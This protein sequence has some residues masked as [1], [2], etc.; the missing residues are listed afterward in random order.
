MRNA[1]FS[2]HRRRDGTYTRIAL[3]HPRPVVFFTIHLHA[4]AHIKMCVTFGR[5]GRQKWH[6]IVCWM[7]LVVIVYDEKTKEANNFGQFERSRPRQIPRVTSQCILF[8]RSLS[9]PS[10]HLFFCNFSRRVT[11]PLCT[12]RASFLFFHNQTT[13]F[14]FSLALSRGPPTLNFIREINVEVKNFIEIHSNCFDLLRFR[15]MRTFSSFSPSKHMSVA[16]FVDANLLSI[17]TC[18]RESQRPN[19]EPDSLAEANFLQ[20][21][22]SKI[23]NLRGKLNNPEPKIKSNRCRDSIDSVQQIYYSFWVFRL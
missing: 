20:N 23:I 3:I 2:R 21:I 11:I 4:Y 22:L 15:I 19:D 5:R 14:P 17:V 9:S 1:R 16:A 6:G 8:S 18:Q 7:G 13:G 12:P 10:L